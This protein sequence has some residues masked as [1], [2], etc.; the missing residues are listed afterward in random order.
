[1]L[2]NYL[3]NV[4]ADTDATISITSVEV[5]G[6]TVT[7]KVAATDSV[8]LGAI[9]GTLK[10]VSSDTLPVSGTPTYIEFTANNGVATIAIPNSGKFIKA[11]V[12]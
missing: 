2:D 5:S 11:T 8:D 4:P 6:T 3:L 1:M 9:N 12:E 7:I 10:V